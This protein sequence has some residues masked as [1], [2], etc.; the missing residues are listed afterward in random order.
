MAS[1]W[2]LEKKAM[3][4][5]F[6]ILY[7]LC[8]KKRPHDD[9]AT[10]LKLH[11][12]NHSFDGPLETICTTGKKLYVSK[13]FQNEAIE[14]LASVIRESS[15]QEV[16]RSPFL[17]GITDETMDCTT[18]SNLVY[19]YRTCDPNVGTPK[20]VLSSFEALEHGGER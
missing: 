12:V 2:D 15:M 18:T 13:L 8:Q 14:C 6:R 3:L 20:I 4:I 10:L 5:R 7:Y 16:A 1:T 19:L 17:C 9:F 11:R